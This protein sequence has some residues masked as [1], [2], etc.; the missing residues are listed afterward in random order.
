MMQIP[1]QML[2]Y[3]WHPPTATSTEHKGRDEEL[4]CCT[5]SAVRKTVKDGTV[6]LQ[7]QY[8]EQKRHKVVTESHTVLTEH[9]QFRFVEFVQR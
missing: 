3:F 5:S 2:T 9:C 6:H 4:D 7:Q 8:V 1:L